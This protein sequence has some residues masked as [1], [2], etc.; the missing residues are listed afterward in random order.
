M[1][2][3]TL[4]VSM[5]NWAL[6]AIAALTMPAISAAEPPRLADSE[7]SDLRDR[8]VGFM[9]TAK[10]PGFAIVVVR[11]DAVIVL[12]GF[13]VVNVETRK[14][15]TTDT[16][17]YIASCTKSFNALLAVAGCSGPIPESI[18]SR[19]R[20]EILASLGWC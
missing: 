19:V 16:M 8:W 7:L 6:L 18:A 11:G 1:N 9:E 20:G 2:V 13:G 5:K 4:R 10:I 12:D 14:R 15:V 3:R 17:F